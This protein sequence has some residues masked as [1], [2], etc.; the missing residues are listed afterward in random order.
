MKKITSMSGIVC[1]AALLVA[2]S[3]CSSITQQQNML[4][5]AGFKALPANSPQRVEHLKSLSDDRL[6]TV[7]LNGYNY[8]VFPNWAEGV[9]FVG[10]EPQYERYQ[11]MR[12]ENEMPEARVETATVDDYW[13]LWRAWGQWR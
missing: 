5:A 8:F 12:L 11:R 4:S 3:G 2:A 6:T 1:A 9:L 10:Q 7:D 13:P